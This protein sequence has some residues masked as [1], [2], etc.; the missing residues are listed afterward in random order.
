MKY[1][2]RLTK[3]QFDLKYGSLEDTD[4]ED[5]SFDCIDDDADSLIDAE[6]DALEENMDPKEEY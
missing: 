3:E 6:L 1:I 4:I 2:S 5:D